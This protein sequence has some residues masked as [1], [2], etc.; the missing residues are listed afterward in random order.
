MLALLYEDKAFSSQ[1]S[2]TAGTTLLSGLT[3]VTI[4]LFVVVDICVIDIP[5]CC[6]RYQLKPVGFIYSAKWQNTR[7]TSPSSRL[8]QFIKILLK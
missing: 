2:V 5:Q 7:R 8:S 6:F 3:Y 1:L 4:A